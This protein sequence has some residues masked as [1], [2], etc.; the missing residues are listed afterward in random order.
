MNNFNLR[1]ECLDERDDYHAI[2]KKQSKFKETKKPPRVQD[3]DQHDDD[4]DL[5]IGS[6]FEEDYGDTKKMLGP[7]AIKKAQQMIETEIM[8]NNAGWSDV[9]GVTKFNLDIEGF[10]LTIYKSGSEWRNIVKQSRETLL[11]KARK[12]NLPS[13]TNA[14]QAARHEIEDFNFE[15]SAVKLL[16][17]E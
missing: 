7:N 2:L 12:K 4:C 13:T 1:Y 17:A 14:L 3:Q 10:L 16:S 8:M 11:L 9:D 5:G 15:P 6:N